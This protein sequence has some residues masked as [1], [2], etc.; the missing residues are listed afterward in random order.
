[1]KLPSN[2]T[3]A[4]FI[5][6]FDQVI[7]KLAR[8]FV[9]GNREESDI[10]QE[11]FIIAMQGLEKFDGKR[12]LANF[13]YIHIRNRLCNYKRKHY[14]RKEPP[15]TRCPLKAFIKPDKCSRYDDMMDCDLYE[16]WHKRNIIK[17]NLTN[18]LE[19]GQVIH[20][21][22]TEENMKYSLDLGGGIDKQEIT[23]LLNKE[24]PARFRK[25]YTML[26]NGIKIQKKDEE[27][28]KLEI[29]KI[30]KDNGYEL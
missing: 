23:N 12:P 17:R 27:A 14:M 30:L 28:L 25:H 4:Q 9:F 16:R 3:E 22:T 29:I 26:I 8:K 24:L 19:Y 13:L 2:Y 7:K 21:D 15:C 20:G 5:E 1:M 11:A 6:T 18:T 10:Y